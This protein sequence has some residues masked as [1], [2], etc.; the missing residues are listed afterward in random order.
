MIPP[1]HVHSAYLIQSPLERNALACLILV[2]VWM[3]GTVP[4]GV[5]NVALGWPGQ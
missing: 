4:P 1:A 5:R 2:L 3:T